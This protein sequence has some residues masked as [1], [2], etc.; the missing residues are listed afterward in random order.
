MSPGKT[1]T[2]TE[3]LKDIK[4]LFS[5]P[6][7][8]IIVGI[9]DDAA[10]LA[11]N[12]KH[13]VYTC[14]SQVENTH[15]KT[16]EIHPEQLGFRA[17]SAGVSDIAAMGATPQHLLIS[18][19][20]PKRPDTEK[21][22]TGINHGIAQACKIYNT[23]VIGGNITKSPVFA[24][25][26]FAIGEVAPKHL[27]KKSGA[28]PGDA[29]FVTGFLG[30]AHTGWDLLQNSSVVLSEKHKQY[31]YTHHFKP[32]AKVPEA[33]VLANLGILTA[34]TDMSDGLATDLLNLCNASNVGVIVIAKDIPISPAVRAYAA[35]AKKNALTL[36]LEG[37]E[38]FALCFTVPEK[39]EGKI[40]Q[41]VKQKTGTQIYRVGTI[42]AKEKGKTIML[43]T[44]EIKQ[45]TAIGF[46]N[47]A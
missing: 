10:V 41:T 3:L 43:P 22:V 19:F 33:Q 16:Q 29:V 26:V 1:K 14:D 42:C 8:D 13:L 18:L 30:D 45:L 5:K 32:Y 20:V 11:P 24:I 21:W 17:V 15:F 39:Y 4:K 38:D 6:H 46:D 31:L 40:I 36:A 12:K 28:K 37:G 27:L 47:L 35:A 2:E 9:G 25:D 23:T 44:G 7:R 34:M